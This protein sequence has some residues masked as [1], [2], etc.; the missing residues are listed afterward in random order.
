MSAPRRGEV[1]QV[2]LDS[3]L[4]HEQAGSRPALVLSVDA[5]NAATQLATVLPIT[6]KARAVRTRV[7]VQ[8]S[9]GGLTVPSYVICEQPRT[10]S[11]VRFLRRLGS[12]SPPTL[13]AVENVVRLLL[14]L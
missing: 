6:S 14:G 9:E 5:V 12:A 11:G 8:P 1:W 4:G 7:A 13:A 10:I 2:N 3:V